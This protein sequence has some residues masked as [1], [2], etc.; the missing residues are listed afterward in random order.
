MVNAAM[1]LA[2]WAETL[3]VRPNTKYAA[4]FVAL[5]SEAKAARRGRWRDTR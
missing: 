5:Q 3:E 1:V 4:L 2:G